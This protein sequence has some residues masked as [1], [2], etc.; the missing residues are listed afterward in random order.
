MTRTLTLTGLAV[1]GTLILLSGH[2]RLAG[3]AGGPRPLTIE[4]VKPGLYAIRLPSPGPTV[5]VRVTGDGVILVDSLYEAN[6][7]Q[8]A[9]LVRSVTPQPIKYVIS[10]H[11][12][13]D[14]TGANVRFMGQAQIVGHAK[15]RAAMTGI[16][17]LPGAPPLTYTTEAAIHLG[18][19]EVQL[20]H[21]GRGHTDGDT[22]VYFPDL[23]VVAT[24]DLFV[25]ID[26]PPVIDYASGGT[27]IGWL[28]TLDN[29]LRFDFDVAIPGHGPIAA[30]ADVEAFKQKLDT[31]QTR[32]RRLIQE[33]VAKD[34]YLGRLQVD[35]LGWHVDARTLF[36]RMS[37]GGLYDELAKPT[38]PSGVRSLR[39]VWRNTE[40]VIPATT[41]P[42]DRLDPFA[43][44]PVGRQTDVQPGLLIFTDTHY[45][46]TTDIAVQPR[47][48]T[49]YATAGK[50]TL[51]E[52]QARWGP[53]AANAGT[54]EVSGDTVTLRAIVSKE[55]RDQAPG[56]FARL[57]VTLE[58]DVLS[59]TPVER[60]E[61][62]IAAGVTSRYVRVE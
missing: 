31:L 13:A 49:G 7:D 60:T 48:T 40:R 26:R 20:H 2:A 28:P 29:I 12:H 62:P 8:I 17:A 52:L 47:P 19:A 5:S 39:G 35:D 30:R 54:Y 55:P 41:R 37:A 61:G 18:G 27:A 33:G 38:P 16:A 45:S 32:T 23:R 14:H 43:H 15:A 25:M 1:A 59:L 34:G 44:V 56:G 53:F 50:P 58:G 22:I 51:E 36:V 3:Q 11:H 57:R 21:V 6:Y 9:A 46:R 42:G 4:A 10:T 24:G